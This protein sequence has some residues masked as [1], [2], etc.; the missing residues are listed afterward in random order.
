MTIPKWTN[1]RTSS[2]TLNLFSAAA[3]RISQREMA[4]RG[5]ESVC[6]HTHR[7]A[8]RL[9]VCVCVCVCALAGFGLGFAVSRCLA[10]PTHNQETTSK[11]AHTVR[12]S[13]QRASQR[14]GNMAPR[15]HTAFSSVCHYLCHFL[16]ANAIVTHNH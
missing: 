11:P 13:Q 7:L 16:V 3:P 9:R 5:C 14:P 2:H 8:A 1:P 15:P 6:E 10:Y 12:S 4:G